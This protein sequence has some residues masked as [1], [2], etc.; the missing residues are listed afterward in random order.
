MAASENDL[1]GVVPSR[2]HRVKI[3]TLFQR[4]FLGVTHIR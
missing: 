3:I 2:L 1:A 4:K